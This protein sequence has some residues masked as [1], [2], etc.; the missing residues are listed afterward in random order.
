MWKAITSFLPGGKSSTSKPAGTFT[1]AA[2]S[3][4]GLPAQAAPLLK[5]MK[6]KKANTASSISTGSKFPSFSSNLKQGVN[7][8]DPS[9]EEVYDLKISK[10][11]FN[12]GDPNPFFVNVPAKKYKVLVSDDLEVKPTEEI[13]NSTLRFYGSSAENVY[14]KAKT[15]KTSAKS[16]HNTLF[17]KA[18]ANHR[19]R[20]IKN[21]TNKNKARLNATKKSD[22]QIQKF[23]QSLQKYTKELNEF[24][25]LHAYAKQ[26]IIPGTAF[27]KS[28][29]MTPE[30]QRKE[31]K[32]LEA[33]IQGAIIGIEEVRKE[34]EKVENLPI[35][36]RVSLEN[37]LSQ[38]KKAADIAKAENVTTSLNNPMI[39]QAAVSST[40]GKG[41][42]PNRSKQLKNTLAAFG[43][44][45]RPSAGRERSPSGNSRA[46]AAGTG[47][48][49]AAGTGA[50]GADTSFLNPLGKPKPIATNPNSIKEAE[51]LLR[52]RGI[53]VEALGTG[54]PAGMAS[55][56]TNGNETPTGFARSPGGTLTQV[57]ETGAGAS[58]AAAARAVAAAGVNASN[59]PP[60]IKIPAA[61]E[62]VNASVPKPVAAAAPPAPA[63]GG[64]SRKR[65]NQKKRK[66]RTAKRRA[67][68]SRKH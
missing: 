68:K 7:Y 54:T 58:A 30:V 47:A 8:A 44:P 10:P 51:A 59:P 34:M 35:D 23:R 11:K 4:A 45:R 46:S 53:N 50:A 14:K 28:T 31:I 17:Q 37:A 6:N 25:K 21:I 9:D 40:Q 15:Y 56:S 60:P 67:G 16:K 66:A 1:S 18:Q 52:A 61:G 48:S 63:Q 49:A 13:T 32:R 43:S 27:K 64:G 55:P 39:K 24:L 65:R 41:L 42:A 57:G 62:A 22:L 3:S 29:N 33:L 26:G 19:A 2:A 20:V 38:S 5:N 36:V 12:A